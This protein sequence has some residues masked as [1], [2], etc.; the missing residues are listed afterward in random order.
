MNAATVI[1]P[2][3]RTISSIVNQS[4]IGNLNLRSSRLLFLFHRDEHLVAALAVRAPDED[5]GEAAGRHLLELAAGI[6]G[7]RDRLAVDRE[8]HVAHPQAA[9]RFAA[10]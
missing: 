2:R 10:R 1:G 6:G 3:S 9:R 5:A 8:N 7:A 4:D